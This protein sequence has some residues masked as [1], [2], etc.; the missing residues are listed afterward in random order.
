MELPDDVCRL[1]NEYARPITRGNW[2]NGSYL[3]SKKELFKKINYQ[4]KG[5]EYTNYISPFSYYMILN[6]K[7]SFD[8]VLH[9]FGDDIVV[10]FHYEK[11]NNTYM[12]RQDYIKNEIDYF[13]DEIE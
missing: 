9:A 8:D 3:A 11:H 1:I 7:P 4:E 2:R 6:F 13:Y 12:I 5:T 10:S